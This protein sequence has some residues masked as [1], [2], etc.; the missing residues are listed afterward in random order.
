MQCSRPGAYLP[1][2]LQSRSQTGVSQVFS[3]VACGAWSG[4]CSQRLPDRV[5]PS[6]NITQIR[7]KTSLLM[8]S[9]VV[10]VLTGNHVGAPLWLSGRRDLN[11]K[12]TPLTEVLEASG[13]GLFCCGAPSF[14]PVEAVACWINNERTSGAAGLDP[15]APGR[16]L[17]MIQRKVRPCKS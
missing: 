7:A 14:S 10:R 8:L 13:S 11:K 5:G 15:R 1:P 17:A 9:P 4:G 2:E 12:L 6:G 16:G 3:P